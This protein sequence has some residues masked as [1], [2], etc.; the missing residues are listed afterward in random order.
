MERRRCKRGDARQRPG[1]NNCAHRVGQFG[2]IYLNQH[3]FMVFKRFGAGIALKG[4]VRNAFGQGAGVMHSFAWWPTVVVLAVATFTDLR[5]RRI[6]NW[7]VFPFFGCGVVVSVCAARLARRGTEFERS[8]SRAADLRVSLLDGRNG[9]G[10]R[11]VVRSHWCVDWPT[12]AVLRARI[13]R[14][15]RRGDGSCHCGLGRIP[16]GVISTHGR[17]GFQRA[18]PRRSSFE[19]SAAAQDAVCTGNRDRDIDFVF[20]TLKTEHGSVEFEAR[21]V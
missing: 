12:S 4:V 15:G 21:Q 13:Y 17:F 16:E 2:L 9:R 14:L 19:Q 11:E 6:P 1:V 18:R 5:S 8:G 10:R 20:R 7:L 3:G